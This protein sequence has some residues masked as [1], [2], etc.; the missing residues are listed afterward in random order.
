MSKESGITKTAN[1]DLT[2]KSIIWEILVLR[3]DFRFFSSTE[4]M[5][6]M[7]NSDP[8]VHMFNDVLLFVNIIVILSGVLNCGVVRGKFLNNKP[9]RWL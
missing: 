2:R 7:L 3:A 1:Y 6:N 5:T 4:P 8:A 9:R